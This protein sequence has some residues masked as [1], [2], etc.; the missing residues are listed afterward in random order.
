MTS[1]LLVDKIEGKTTANTVQMPSGSIIQVV[2]NTPTSTTHITVASSSLVEASTTMRTTITPK[3]ATSLLR[4]H[5]HC[6]TGGRNTSY[7]M[8]YKFYDITNSANVGSS[9]LGTGS[10]RTF[11]NASMR[12]QDSDGNDRHT[13]S[14]T[15]YQSANT[16]TARTYGIYASV[17]SATMD[18]NMTATDNAGCSYSPPIF[19][20]EEIAQ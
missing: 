8:N 19:T 1:R 2:Q 16:T 12:T 4:L 9:S 5:F 17:E 15:A 20:I 13:L 11:V 3:F 6:L 18:F 14:M 10:S 7:I